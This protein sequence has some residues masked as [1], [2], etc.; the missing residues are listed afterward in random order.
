M[1]LSG[2]TVIELAAIGPVPFATHLFRQ[3]GARV[4]VVSPPVDRGLGIPIPREHDYLSHGKEQMVLDLKSDE[5][6]AGLFELL[7]HADVLLEGFRPG[8]LERLDLCPATLRS[9]FPAL[10]VGRCSGWGTSSPLASTAGHDINYL[11]LSGALA[12]I[13]TDKP[14]PPLNLVADYGGA[15]MHL[16]VGV[17]GAMYARQRDGR[18]TVVETSI[19]EGTL[20]LMTLFYSLFDAGQWRDARSSNL[21]DGGAPFYCC[22]QCADGKWMAVGAIEEKFYARFIQAIGADLDPD[23]QHD[24]SAWAHAYS[25]IAARMAERT[26]DEWCG[27]FYNI[28]CCCSPV[29]ELSEVRTHPDAKSLFNEH[30]PKPPIR[31]SFDR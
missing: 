14:T 22:Y 23:K 19:F 3:L 2:A 16:A 18:G 26:R 31:Y 1:P 20:S 27:V 30:T 4:I 9:R 24:R 6:R 28:D 11:A 12:A 17:I 29:L 21:L 5:G 25:E 8:T 15:A 10:I 13:G 7:E